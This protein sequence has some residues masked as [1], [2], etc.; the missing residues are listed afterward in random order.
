MKKILIIA[1]AICAVL[2]LAGCGKRESSALTPD[3]EGNA[4]TQKSEKLYYS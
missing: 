2:M 3:L 1:C 4:T